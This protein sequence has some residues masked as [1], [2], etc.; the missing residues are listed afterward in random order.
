MVARS[1]RTSAGDGRSP[2][3]RVLAEHAGIGDGVRVD[4]A[5]ARAIA[6]VAAAN[7]RPMQLVTL[8]DATTAGG[9][10]RGQA[11]AQHAR[12]ARRA[13]DDR[14]A[15]FSISVESAEA[16]D[17]GSAAELVGHLLGAE[18]SPAL[19]G[20][21]LVVGSG[22]LGVRSHPRPAAS[23]TLGGSTIPPWFDAALREVVGATEDH[24]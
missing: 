4:A 6:D 11:A 10:S 3:E 16:A 8:A 13:T 23:F 22:W 17:R 14:V 15:A 1:G 21:E 7:Q 18:D 19:S 12:A 5:W 24:G 20:A 2:W 9:R